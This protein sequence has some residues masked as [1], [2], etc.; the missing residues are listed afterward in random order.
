[1]SLQKKKQNSECKNR[2]SSYQLN[3]SLSELRCLYF[4]KNEKLFVKKKPPL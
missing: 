4:C 3:H 1:M 2:I